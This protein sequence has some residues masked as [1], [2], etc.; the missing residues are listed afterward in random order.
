MSVSGW[1][2]RRPISLQT[3]ILNGPIKLG[4]SGSF[5]VFVNSLGLLYQLETH[6]PFA[7]IASGEGLVQT[8]TGF[9]SLPVTV[10]DDLIDPRFLNPLARFAY[11]L[12]GI[13]NHRPVPVGEEARD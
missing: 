2:A 1:F 10:M 7:G 11:R 6:P 13:G 5:F 9:V 3:W 4:L 12:A 8:K